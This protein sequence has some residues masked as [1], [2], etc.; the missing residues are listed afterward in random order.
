TITARL[1]QSHPEVY[2]ANGG[3]TFVILPLLEQVVGNVRH[4]LW[5]LLAAVACVLLIACVNV[6][7]LLLS[8]AVGRQREIAVRTAVGASAGRIV[9]QLLTESVLLAMGGGVLGILLAVLCIHW[10]R[11]LGPQSVPRLSE[12]GV[13]ADALLFTLLISIVSG[14]LFGLAL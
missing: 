13:R 11:I 14:V 4:T 12:V 3:L 8:R 6:A 10:T 9:R 7:N 1:R 2:P 5:L